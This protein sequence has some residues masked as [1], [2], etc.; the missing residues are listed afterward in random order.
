MEPL[1]LLRESAWREE[2]AVK[3]GLIGGG[4]KGTSC[5]GERLP[6]HR[7]SLGNACP[8]R[9][10]RTEVGLKNYPGLVHH[11]EAPTHP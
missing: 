2:H 11:V 4:A 7:R 8:F 9:R 3:V 6:P 10:E 5:W 1:I